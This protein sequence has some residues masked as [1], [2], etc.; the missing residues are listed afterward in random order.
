MAA[1]ARYGLDDGSGQR[2]SIR[3]E[4][5]WPLEICGIRIS[6]ERLMRAQPMYTGA[7]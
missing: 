2:S 5:S 3:V 6:A 4:F 7:S 1:K